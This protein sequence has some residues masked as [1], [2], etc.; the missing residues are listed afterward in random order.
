MVAWQQ[1]V[2]PR[3][4]RRVGEQGAQRGI[5]KQQL[6]ARVDDADGVFELLDRGLEVGELG[7]FFNAVSEQLSALKK[8]PSSPNSSFSPRF[9]WTPN[10]PR[11]KIGR[12]HV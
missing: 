8:V 9:T 6:A 12:A 10:S 3:A 1:R 4:R 5:R 11:P 2:E 7:T